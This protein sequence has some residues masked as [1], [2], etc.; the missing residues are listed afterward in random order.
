MTKALQNLT[1]VENIHNISINGFQGQGSR[2]DTDK[3]VRNTWKYDKG[4]RGAHIR[5]ETQTY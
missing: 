1:I 3:W 5:T 4:T 2:V